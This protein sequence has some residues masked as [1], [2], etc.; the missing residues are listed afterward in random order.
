MSITGIYLRISIHTQYHLQVLSSNQVHE[1]TYFIIHITHLS[2]SYIRLLSSAVWHWLTTYRRLLFTVDWEPEV[3]LSPGSRLPPACSTS[4]PA[5]SPAHQ[6]ACLTTFV[7]NN[8]NPCTLQF[9]E[10]QLQTSNTISNVK[11]N[12]AWQNFERYINID[13]LL[14]FYN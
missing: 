1:I 11:C 2:S 9:R 4:S 6:C 14:H 12:E 13:T 5:T 3:K 8:Y 7:L 10:Q